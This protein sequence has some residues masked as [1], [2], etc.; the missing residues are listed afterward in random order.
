LSELNPGIVFLALVVLAFSLS[1][2]ELAH[3]AT[4]RRLGDDTAARQGRVTLN[5]AA[6]VDV[7][8]TIVFPLVALVSGIPLLGWAKPVP[9]DP[10]NL[11]HPRRDLILIA[12]AGPA[13]NLLLALLV[14]I[15]WQL[16]PGA[17]AGRPDPA[18]L[19]A[20][21]QQA[22]FLNVSL[23]VFNMLPIP[24]LDGGNVLGNLLPPRQGDAFDSF[25]R[26]YG[27]LI[28]Y[29]LMFTGGLWAILGP[30]MLFLANLL[31]L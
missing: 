29:A 18:T 13:S 5:P 7:I 19:W 9:V 4:A 3:A 10:R 1:V 20:V 14:S 6:H 17:P 8:G 16:V 11:R 23:A 2:H 25:M 24:P 30:P 26:P 28:L 22:F 31:W 12:V 27:F 21:G 15:V